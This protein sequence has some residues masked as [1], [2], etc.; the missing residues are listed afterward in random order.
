MPGYDRKLDPLTGDYMDA[1]GGEY[2][3]TLGAETA[4]QHALRGERDRWW[5]DPN[6]GSRLYQ[7]RTRNLNQPTVAW[8][9]NEVL[10]AL[11]PLI[12]EGLIADPQFRSEA[13]ARGRMRMET[14]MNDLATG[15]PLV[16]APPIGGK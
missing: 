16:I 15:E 14:T 2:A 3:E 11:Q 9:E 4:V 6:R 10:A 5:G 7:I 13:D 8:T 12:D 1:P